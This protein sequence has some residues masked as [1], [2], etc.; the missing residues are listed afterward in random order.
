MKRDLQDLIRKLELSKKAVEKHGARPLLGRFRSLLMMLDFLSSHIQ[1]PLARSLFLTC[2]ALYQHLNGDVEIFLKAASLFPSRRSDVERRR[3]VFKMLF[4]AGGLLFDTMLD[5]TSFLK[6]NPSSEEKERLQTKLANDAREVE[7]FIVV[8]QSSPYIKDLALKLA[9]ESL[10]SML[11]V[12][13]STLL[14]DPTSLPDDR[15]QISIP[16]SKLEGSFGSDSPGDQIGM[17]AYY[18][19]FA[20]RHGFINVR[21]DGLCFF[22]ALLASGVDPHLTAPELQEM[23]LIAL[24]H[25]PSL[26]EFFSASGPDSFDQYIRGRLIDPL[27]WADEPVIAA[28]AANLGIYLTIVQYDADD[29]YVASYSYGSP[30]L[31]HVTIV[32]LDNMHFFGVPP[33]ET[34]FASLFPSLS[35]VA[36]I[37]RAYAGSH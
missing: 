2:R 20:R 27:A 8:L 9:A 37:L 11:A 1:S 17:T 34:T 28:T 29:Q 6:K 13:H 36:V 30:A 10:V 12:V 5:Y 26:T 31:T 25:D 21:G 24:T 32:N 18:E 22:N 15:S 35:V 16:D 33:L 14:A 19:E 3:A 7:K 23:A 4:Q